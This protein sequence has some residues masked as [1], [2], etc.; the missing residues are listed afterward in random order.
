MD[1]GRYTETAF[2][3]DPVLERGQAPGPA[4]RVDRRRTVG[5]CQL[6]QPIG[7]QVFPMGRRGGELV[8]VRCDLAG[9]V[10]PDP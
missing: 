1:H 5:P 4:D 6:P 7:S 3:H 8:L 10:D 9:V 2:V